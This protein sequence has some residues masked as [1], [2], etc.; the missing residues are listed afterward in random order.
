[1]RLVIMRVGDR[2]TAQD[3]PSDYPLMILAIVGGKVAI[4]SPRW[5]MYATHPVSLHQS[6]KSDHTDRDYQ[7][8]QRLTPIFAGV[9]GKLL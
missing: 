7:S 1:M 3:F 2:V 9:A 5:P 6:E 4:G 8:I